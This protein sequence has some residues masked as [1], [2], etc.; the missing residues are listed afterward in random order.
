M[1]V[2]VGGYPA[3]DLGNALEKSLRKSM[4][5]K[6]IN[7][8]RP[9][10]EMLGRKMQAVAEAEAEQLFPVITSIMEKVRG[11]VLEGPQLTYQDLIQGATT[12]LSYG[13]PSYVSDAPVEWKPLSIEYYDRKARFY[14]NADNMFVYFGDLRR[15]FSRYGDS[16]IRNR[17]GGVKVD[18]TIPDVS[19]QMYFDSA[20]RGTH[21]DSYKNIL[22]GNINVSIFPNLAPSL[23]SVMSGHSWNDMVGQEGQFEAELFAGTEGVIHKLMNAPRSTSAASGGYRPLVLPAVQFWIQVRI[24]NAIFATI[25]DFTRRATV[26]H[27]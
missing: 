21:E 15:Y 8:S 19:K 11:D 13:P 22:L 18:V 24:P 10:I 25:K 12:G 2:T 23:L 27:A 7:L 14:R 1:K 26:R 9:R 3:A 16:I 5:A 6:S 20:Y 17:L 4:V